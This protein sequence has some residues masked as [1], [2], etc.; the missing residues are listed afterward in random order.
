VLRVESLEAT[1]RVLTYQTK[2][3]LVRWLSAEEMPM[4][5]QS[6]YRLRRRI[7]RRWLRELFNGPWPHPMASSRDAYLRAM[8][9]RCCL[10]SMV[11]SLTGLCRECRKGVEAGAS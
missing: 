3:P 11:V 2:V 8:C 10:P 6:R 7:Q 5:G 1:L 4:I 9:V